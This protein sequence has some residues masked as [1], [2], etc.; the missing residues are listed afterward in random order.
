MEKER[1]IKV[2]KAGGLGWAVVDTGKY[3]GYPAA[4]CADTLAA[5]DEAFRLSEAH[6]PPLK[7][8]IDCRGE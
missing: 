2:Y 7:I 4:H 5:L 8:T 1:E 3:G 6:T